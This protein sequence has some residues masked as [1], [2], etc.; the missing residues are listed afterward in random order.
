MIFVYIK[1]FSSTPLDGI[2]PQCTATYTTQQTRKD[3][4]L[5]PIDGNAAFDTQTVKANA[6]SHVSQSLL[7]RMQQDQQVFASMENSA[8]ISKLLKFLSNDIQK[9]ITFVLCFRFYFLFY[10]FA[11]MREGSATMNQAVQHIGKLLTSLDAALKQE[12]TYQAIP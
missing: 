2:I 5:S 12:S 11:D 8:S 6:R 10:I 1:F 3:Q 9:C 7:T 4:G